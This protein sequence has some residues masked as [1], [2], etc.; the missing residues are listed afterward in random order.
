MTVWAQWAAALTKSKLDAMIARS[1]RKDLIDRVQQADF[2]YNLNEWQA[3]V[4]YVYGSLLKNLVDSV[5]KMDTA[6]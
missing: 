4:T 2:V 1:K 3:I 5:V 6:K